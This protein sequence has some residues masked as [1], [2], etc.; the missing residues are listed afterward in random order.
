VYEYQCL[1]S[2]S[3]KAKEVLGDSVRKKIITE[4]KVTDTQLNGLTALQGLKLL[5]AVCVGLVDNYAQ[6]KQ[7]MLAHL[8]WPKSSYQMSYSLRNSPEIAADLSEFCTLFFEYNSIL[9]HGRPK[10]QQWMEMKEGTEQL[11][12]PFFLRCCMPNGLGNMLHNIVQQ[13]NQIN[14]RGMSLRSYMDL[15]EATFRRKFFKVHKLLDSTESLFL[16]AVGTKEDKAFKENFR[17]RGYHKPDVDT[18]RPK[19]PY[20]STTMDRHRYGKS[21]SSKSSYSAYDQK[22]RV[23]PSLRAIQHV[24][25]IQER[26]Y[27]DAGSTGVTFAGQPDDD[28]PSDSDDDSDDGTTDQA[29]RDIDQEVH[30]LQTAILEITNRLYDIRALPP[31]ADQ[32]CRASMYNVCKFGTQCR[33]SHDEGRLREQ[34]RDTFRGIQSYK[35]KI[36]AAECQEITNAAA[37][38]AARPS[39]HDRSQQQPG[40][41]GQAMQAG[42]SPLGPAPSPAEFQRK[43]MGSA[44]QGTT[45]LR[46]ITAGS[47]S[48]PKPTEQRVIIPPVK[49]SDF[50]LSTT[51]RTTN[52]E[53]PIIA[54][55]MVVSGFCRPLNYANKDT[56]E[57]QNALLDI[58]SSRSSFIDPQFI[59]RHSKWITR[60][61][62]DIQGVSQTVANGETTYANK[63]I[64]LE[65]TIVDA[66]GEET[67]FAGQFIILPKSVFTPPGHP[68]MDII[69]GQPHL[70][71]MIP[72]LFCKL[73]AQARAAAKA[74]GWQSLL[75]AIEQF[76]YEQQPDE[77]ADYTDVSPAAFLSVI[78]ASKPLTKEE[79]QAET[80]RL[81]R[82]RRRE[83]FA[84]RQQQRTQIYVDTPPQRYPDDT[85]GGARGATASDENYVAPL[86]RAEQLAL[87]SILETSEEIPREQV[88]DLLHDYSFALAGRTML[89]EYQG[90][91][92]YMAVTSGRLNMFAGLHL[93]DRGY[94]YAVRHGRTVGFLQSDQE[95]R[96]SYEGFSAAEHQKF[97]N[98]MDAKAYMLAPVGSGPYR[99]GK[100]SKHG[101]RKGTT[102]GIQ[103]HST[104]NPVA[105]AA[106][107][108]TVASVI[109]TRQSSTRSHTTRTCYYCGCTILL[110]GGKTSIECTGTLNWGLPCHPESTPQHVNQ[111]LYLLNSPQAAATDLTAMMTRAVMDPIFGVPLG[112]TSGFH[113]VIINLLRDESTRGD[114]PLPFGMTMRRAYS[115][116]AAVAEFWP[117]FNEIRPNPNPCPPNPIYSITPREGE[118]KEEVAGVSSD[119]QTKDDRDFDTWLAQHEEWVQDEKWPNRYHAKGYVD[120]DIDSS[121]FYTGHDDICDRYEED[122]Q[123]GGDEYDEGAD[124]WDDDE[125][126]DVDMAKAN[127]GNEPKEHDVPKEKPPKKPGR[128]PVDKTLYTDP[129]IKNGDMTEPWLED[130]DIDPPEDVGLDAPNGPFPHVAVAMSKSLRENIEEYL[131]EIPKQ[132][133]AGLLAHPGVEDI[134]RGKGLKAFVAHNWEGIA[135]PPVE[136]QWNELNPLPYRHKPTMRSINPKITAPAQSEMERM[137]GYFFD[138]SNSPIASALVMVYKK[139]KPFVRVCHDYSWMRDHIK[140]PHHQMPD[141]KLSLE[142]MIKYKYYLDIDLQ[143]AYN[144]IPICAADAARLSVVTPW[145]QF[146]PRFMPFGIPPASIELQKIME[147]LFGDLQECSII[148]MDGLLIGATDYEDAKNKL[149]MV[150]DKCLERNV[151]LRFPK[152]HLG[153][154]EVEFWGYQLKHGKY[155]FSEERIKRVTELPMPTDKK[156]AKRAVGAAQHF[157]GHVPCFSD[158]TADL[159]DM[160]KDKFNFDRSTWTKDYEKSYRKFLQALSDATENFYPD[161]DLPWVLRTDASDVGCGCV[162]MQLSKHPDGSE[163]RQPIAFVSHKFSDQAF[164]WDT[165]Q[166]ECFAMVWSLKKLQYYLYAKKFVLETDHAN[167]RFLEGSMVPKLVRWKLFMQSFAFDL[168]HIKGVDNVVADW[169]SRLYI[170]QAQMYAIV[171]DKILEK[172]NTEYREGKFP[173]MERCI[174]MVHGSG[175]EPHRGIV[176]TWR[177][178]NTTFPGHHVPYRVVYDYVMTCPSCQKVRQGALD[179]IPPMV[180]HLKPEHHRRRLGADTLTVTPADKWGNH[181]LLVIV[182]LFTKHI[183]LHAM[184]THDEESVAEGLFGYICDTGRVDEIITDPGSEFTAKVFE[185]LC[186][187]MG[188]THRMSLVERHE[189]NGV[190]DTNKHILSRLRAYLGEHRFEGIW[191]S[192]R[193]LKMMEIQINAEFN[194]GI[195][196]DM[197]PM[198]LTFGSADRGYYGINPNN[199]DIANK[200]TW[201]K[202]LDEDLSVLRRVS[203]EHQ[204]ALIAERTAKNVDESL[205]NTYQEGD[206]VLVR[207]PDGQRPPNKLATPWM[208]PYEVISHVKNDVEA[209]H[210]ILGHIKTFFVDRL[211]IFHGTRTAAEKVAEWDNNQHRVR[212]ILAYRGDPMARTTM[213][214]LVQFEDTDESWLT[215]TED[216]FQTQQYADYVN[217]TPELLPLRQSAKVSAVECRRVNRTPI[218]ELTPGE[219]IYVDIRTY[220]Y[221]WYRQMRLPDKDTLTYVT[222]VAITGWSSNKRQRNVLMGQAELYSDDLIEMDH[223]FVMMWGTHRT[224]PIGSVL[225]TQDS[226]TQYPQLDHDTYMS[227]QFEDPVIDAMPKPAKSQYVRKPRERKK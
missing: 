56:V 225:L 68:L 47:S 54:N 20:S 7:T 174:S 173:D 113:W 109:P 133:S 59:Q 93:N 188:V 43:A 72:D 178:M 51:V 213:E 142:K 209:R 226:L 114:V 16:H 101:N 203:A 165:I 85:P 191:G 33:K 13:Q 76:H 73:F 28:R 180:R 119:H 175:T 84:V 80:D 205:R 35:Y 87:M 218:T 25:D 197:S 121:I 162:L 164:R 86:T 176:A 154:E 217:R 22:P 42:L 98:L 193:I 29:K 177:A 69:I 182:N 153:V 192:K 161:Y 158:A 117:Q 74:A 21:H 148:I 11:A 128:T 212:D 64:M 30:G 97:S 134:L 185:Q 67:T 160:T 140:T 147:E 130:I 31:L 38:T 214:F 167:L 75:F 222:R 60:A 169:Q 41:Y 118:R 6:Y 99:T 157:S 136:L 135:M 70:L 171:S 143:A 224:Q 126:E 206:L 223:W 5:R 189:S 159:A 146:Q 149:E 24:Y 14:L 37:R 196:E 95:A 103:P 9:N 115:W 102:S 108:A 94:I 49:A 105:Q 63:M 138:D 27:E 144:Q 208:G 170:L 132:V 34:A 91:C 207:Y 227:A 194:V 152:C 96:A 210:V 3:L 53:Y 79:A 82:Q 163:W 179:T 201:I 40:K 61:I 88:R 184:K 15:L 145:G 141:V 166:K 123:L 204:Q 216:L 1:H 39:N 120:G 2:V 78:L 168:R 46:M 71:A 36:S 155:G 190:E 44:S 62:R 172:W 122:W 23:D 181:Y 89:E 187:W 112:P 17:G 45:S 48:E 26:D 55:P 81:A 219:T 111:P 220:G 52:T 90:A 106:P 129:S 65:L 10:K 4:C 58:G 156:G 83:E 57:F 125:A 131:A 18:P 127:S 100:T 104:T 12:L 77:V 32:L 199:S 139:T 19:A 198:E 151:Y 202:N 211:K 92:D 66:E 215:Y 137:R 195:G 110:T 124:V 186:E 50:V 183:G 200:S 107:L 8:S 221:E 150:I 116:A